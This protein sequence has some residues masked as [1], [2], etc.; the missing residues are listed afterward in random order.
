MSV[1]E[2]GQMDTNAQYGTQDQWVHPTQYDA[3]NAK[4]SKPGKAARATV[5]T[6]QKQEMT[7]RATPQCSGWV[8]EIPWRQC[9]KQQPQPKEKSGQ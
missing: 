9:W 8:K 7:L 3:R 1:A 4:R 6:A 2:T 5:G